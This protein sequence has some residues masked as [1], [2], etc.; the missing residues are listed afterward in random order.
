MQ[1]LT[2][3]TRVVNGQSDYRLTD[4]ATHLARYF[5][6]FQDFED[7]KLFAEM[8]IPL[9]GIKMVNLRPNGQ[10]EYLPVAAEQDQNSAASPSSSSGRC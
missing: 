5:S 8:M 3:L 6:I 9:T 10:P 2:Q 4:M 1:S 7:R